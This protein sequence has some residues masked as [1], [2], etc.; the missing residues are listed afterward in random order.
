MKMLLNKKSDENFTVVVGLCLRLCKVP[1]KNM[2][3]TDAKGT[4]SNTCMF[5]EIHTERKRYSMVLQND[6]TLR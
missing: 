6:Y 2:A 4:R 5:H 1:K 3:L